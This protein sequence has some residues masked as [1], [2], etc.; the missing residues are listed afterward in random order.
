MFLNKLDLIEKEAFV[1]LAVRAAEANGHF[2][3]EEYQM[4]EAYCKE[5]DIG[6]FDAKNLKP[7]EDVIRVFSE[8]DEQH[9]R[10]AVLELVGLM[11]ADGG[12]DEKEKE[13]VT[14][15]VNK[16]GVSEHALK[17]IEATLMKYVDMTRELYGCIEGKD[18]F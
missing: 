9:K 15:F 4:I 2:T 6:F 13:F 12:Y 17:K 10:I 1:S 11:Y 7:M 8:A 3:D 14:D 16:I 18:V 5:M